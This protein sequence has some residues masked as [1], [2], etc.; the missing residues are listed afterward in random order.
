MRKNSFPLINLHN[1]TRA[2]LPNG[3][4]SRINEN[5]LRIT[6]RIWIRDEWRLVLTRN[7]ETEKKQLLSNPRKCSSSG[8]SPDAALTRV[9][10]LAGFCPEA[11][12]VP[13]HNRP[14][15]FSSLLGL[16]SA[17]TAQKWKTWTL[18]ANNAFSNVPSNRL[19]ILGIKFLF[20]F[21]MRVKNEEW[22]ASLDKYLP[23]V[24]GNLPPSWR[25]ASKLHL[26]GFK[27]LQNWPMG[28]GPGTALM[29]VLHL[30]GLQLGGS[31]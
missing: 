29:R 2:K 9:L 18:K 25:F 4:K 24:F 6:N 16:M 27:T 30:Y 14:Q 21:F 3:K 10:H 19:G 8:A 5:F 20:L 22:N 1:F 23:F 11:N 17:K 15:Q 31:L 28:A 7:P 13:F 12:C 26:S